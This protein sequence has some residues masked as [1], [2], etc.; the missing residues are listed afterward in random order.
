MPVRDLG[1]YFYL[2]IAVEVCVG[3]LTYL[4]TY[5]LT[6]SYSTTNGHTRGETLKTPGE[7]VEHCIDNQE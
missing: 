7:I 6:T 4:L 5:I 2:E 3:L 1:A